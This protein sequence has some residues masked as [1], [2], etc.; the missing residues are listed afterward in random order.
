MGFRVASGGPKSLGDMYRHV[1]PQFPVDH[2]L[3]PLD[4]MGDREAV[5]L[6]DPGGP[7]AHQCVR[8]AGID[9]G[10]G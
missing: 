5:L 8:S 3:D 9:H 2:S 6:Q 7:G 1:V 4:E 10:E